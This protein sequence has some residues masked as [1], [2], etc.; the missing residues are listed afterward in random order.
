[1]KQ[2]KINNIT[3]KEKRFYWWSGES[4]GGYRCDYRWRNTLCKILDI[5]ETEVTIFDVFKNKEHVWRI[6]SLEKKCGFRKLLGARI[7]QWLKKIT[8]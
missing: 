2:V 8:E 7:T 4:E 1:M 6:E 5:N 3:L